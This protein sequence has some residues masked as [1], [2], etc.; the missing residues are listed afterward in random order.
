MGY[1]AVI[2]LEVHAQLLTD[3]KLFCTCSTEFGAE[4]NNQTCPVCLG[5]PGVLPVLNDRAVDFAIKFGLA[6]DHNP[7]GT[8]VFA[9]KNYFYP[10][11]PKGYQIT[12]FK[13][14]VVGKGRIT[15][16][17]ES[18][19]TRDIG[20]TR[21][22]L[23]EDAGQSHHEG[24]PQSDR[25]SYVNLNRAG[26]PLL[27]IVSEPEIHTPD[28][29]YAYLREMKAI[30]QYLEIC[31]GNME[32]GSMRCDANV[33][34][35]PVG[36]KEFGT[37]T[38]IKNLNSF[39][40]V[41]RSL[42]YEIDRQITTLTHGGEIEQCTLLWDE[43]SQSTKVMRGKED[44]H[45][46]RYFPEPDLLPL[47]ITEERVEA[48]R[49]T[50]P[51]LPHEKYARFME[52]Y[53]LN[54]PDALRLI[55]E[56]PLAEYYEKTAELSGNPRAAC[57]WVMSELLRDLKDLE[58]GVAACPVSPENLAGLV[59]LIDA[60][61][62]SGKIGK[63]VFSAMFAS[64]K[65]PET[66]IE[67]QGLKQITDEGE[68]GRIIDEILAAN[69]SQVADYRG[70]KTKILGFFVGQAMKATRGKGNPATVNQLL[71]Q[72]LDA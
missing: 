43:G 15:I 58:G 10:D 25:K 68:L 72:R 70:G 42:Q 44:S 23:E 52:T 27:E 55:S 57:S 64:G 7:A 1:E 6:V 4:P 20:I 71:R 29:A 28:E 11:L 34:V 61:T 37:R 30:L 65:D 9:R 24:W 59:R 21:A 18:G 13:H 36:Q 69:Q 35:R 40:N 67:E 66:I 60:K 32:E 51:E 41:R 5:M 56:K 31:D 45:D 54:R 63:Q 39:N 48:A 14:P 12:Q 46:Y 26:V 47:T 3:S 16:E 17:L 49:A 53:G 22:H 33:S 62:I 2:G 19:E 8:S 50:L 38:E